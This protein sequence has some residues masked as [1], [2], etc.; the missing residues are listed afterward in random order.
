M[1]LTRSVQGLWRADW[2]PLL[3][4]LLDR[5]EPPEERAASVHM[6][7]AGGIVAQAELIRSQ[8][9]VET[10]GLCGGVFQNARLTSAATGMLEER[11]FE[12]RLGGRVP[13][14]DAG[15]SFGQ[16]VEHAAARRE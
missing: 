16:V 8:A 2:Q 10:V 1:P 7:L 5:R 4:H 13:V 14:N 3:A 15:L 12:V 6:T 9:N 11:G